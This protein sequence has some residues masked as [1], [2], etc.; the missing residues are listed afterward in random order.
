MSMIEGLFAM[1]SSLASSRLTSV[2]AKDPGGQWGIAV[3]HG[4]RR[5][6]F[7]TP[8]QARKDALKLLD[9]ANLAERP[10]QCPA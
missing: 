3:L 7:L 1:V 5:T 8:E 2:V 6:H 10:G 4:G 9:Q